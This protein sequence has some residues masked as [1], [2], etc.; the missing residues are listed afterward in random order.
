MTTEDTENTELKGPRLAGNALIHS[1][2][3]VL[4]V[5]TKAFR[6]RFGKIVTE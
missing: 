4:S 1:V 5:V 2:T 3:P 6:A